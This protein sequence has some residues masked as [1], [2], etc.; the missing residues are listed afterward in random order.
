[1]R[2][3]LEDTVGV[4]RIVVEGDVVFGSELLPAFYA[5]RDFSPVW[6]DANAPRPILEDLLQEVRRAE[7]HGLRPTDYHLRLLDRKLGEQAR[8][9]GSASRLVEIEL[10]ATDAFL[11]YASHLLAGHLN[12]ETST[13]GWFVA[14]PEADLVALLRDAIESR[15]VK[16]AFARVTPADAAYGRLK[17]A[18]RQYRSIAQ[19]GG[20]S[21]VPQGPTLREGA[22]GERVL[23]LKHRLA[24]TDDRFRDLPNDEFDAEVTVAV[25]RFQRAHGLD[26]D[27]IAGPAT[28]RALNIQVQQR[29]EQ[30]RINLERWRW[31]PVNLGSRYVVVNIA[32]FRLYV[33][34]SEQV[35]MT[36]RAIV[37]RPYR[38]TPV[39]SD[40]IS[41]LVFSPYWHVPQSIATRDIL[42]RVQRN[43]E[44]LAAEGFQV[45]RGWSST[46]PIDPATIPWPTVSRSNF[47]YRLRQD[48]GPKNALGGVKFMFPNRFSVYLHDTPA[49]ELFSETSRSFSAGC[50]RVERP[51]DLA[52]YL[53]RDSGTWNGSSVEAA[54]K[55]HRERTVRLSSPV[56]VHL[57]YWTAWAE[58]DGTIQFRDD[59]YNRDGPVR[60]ALNQA[61]PAAG[62]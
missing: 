6:V 13:V 42:P 18:L 25:E 47:P 12:P 1:L 40:T 56:A 11:V 43:P 2:A 36:M 44:Y 16:R 24:A 10:L 17:N 5:S 20:W 55:Q 49:R 58:D 48:P 62:S 53:L 38:N 52:L 8:A 57:L 22:R 27:G 33:V 21:M 51:T 34:E 45:F 32:A 15:D 30:L 46:V 41:Y 19:R 39:M 59:V 29:I 14:R 61:P 37:G 35:V 60:R 9:G 7:D 54:M 31:L 3:R 28:L 4:A 23:A 26:A 50:V